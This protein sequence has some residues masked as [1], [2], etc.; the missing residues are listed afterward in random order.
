[1]QSQNLLG[2]SRLG[3]KEMEETDKHTYTLCSIKVT[4]YLNPTELGLG[5]RIHKGLIVIHAKQFL[6]RAR[7]S[8]SLVHENTNTLT[9]NQF[10]R[11][12]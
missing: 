10:A 11:R 3:T 7:E 1:M 12:E 2:V 5:H 9:R 6:I 8:Q 4:D